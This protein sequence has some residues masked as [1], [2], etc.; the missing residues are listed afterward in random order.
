[1]FK[2]LRKKLRKVKEKAKEV[3]ERELGPERPPARA[4]AESKPVE[5]EVEIM[6]KIFKEFP[7]PQTGV[8]IEPDEALKRIARYMLDLMKKGEQAYGPWFTSGPGFTRVAYYFEEDVRSRAVWGALEAMAEK[9][10]MDIMDSAK[11]LDANLEAL[12]DEFMAGY[13]RSKAELE[14]RDFVFPDLGLEESLIDSPIGVWEGKFWKYDIFSS[15]DYS[16]PPGLYRGENK[17]KISVTEKQVEVEADFRMLGPPFFMSTRLSGEMTAEGEIRAKGTADWGT[18]L[19]SEAFFDLL[20]E[21]QRAQAR[22]MLRDPRVREEYVR[23]MEKEMGKPREECERLIERMMEGK[24]MGGRE[25]PVELTG[26]VN[27]R[28]NKMTNRF[29]GILRPKVP[30]EEITVGESEGGAAKIK[31]GNFYFTTYKQ[32]R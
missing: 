18:E 32:R 8:E 28:E 10:G 23:R 21:S 1:M 7:P 9:R 13:Q 25:T 19:G 5:K 12:A 6:N 20:P 31:M 4:P 15:W 3:A 29:T 14:E 17:I 22:A 30:T 16:Q 24:P 26:K 11:Y 27:L 2:K